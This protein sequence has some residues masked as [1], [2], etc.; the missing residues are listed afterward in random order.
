MLFKSFIIILKILII[1]IPFL[2]SVAFFTIVERKIMGSI[3]IRKGPNIIGYIGL[4]Q[5]FADGLKLFLKENINPNSSDEIFFFLAPILGLTISIISWTPIPFG[6]GYFLADL[7]LGL[8]FI[9][10]TSAI[11]IY[12][13]IF[14]GWGS[15][16]KY[17]FLGCIRSAAQMISY[18]LSFSFSCLIIIVVSGSLNFTKIVLTQFSIFYFI[19]FFPIFFIFYISILAETN[20]HPF[21]LVEAEAE[22]V[23]GYNVEYSS[24]SFAQFFLGEY[25]NMLLTSVFGAILFFGGWIILKNFNLFPNSFILSLKICFGIIFFIINRA[26]LPRFRFDQ[27]MEL[28]WIFLF[29]VVLSY[30]IF[31]LSL[32]I[33]FNGLIVF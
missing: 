19:P 21:D 5:P 7:N 3:Q 12:T 16:S 25:G 24:M 14:A 9:F 29:P 15:N 23:S 13:I 27:L 28:G 8:I 10:C 32:I 6:D 2:I 31:F 1:I 26:I 17:S 4:L 11:N 33:N 22:L 20:R 30:F 18:E